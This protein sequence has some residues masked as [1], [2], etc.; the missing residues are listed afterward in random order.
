[1]APEHHIGLS[2]EILLEIWKIHQAQK[3][4]YIAVLQK[5]LSFFSTLIS[6]A[7]LATIVAASRSDEPYDYLLLLVGPVLVFAL[8]QIAKLGTARSYIAFLEATTVIAKLETDMGLRTSGLRVI[9][10][11]NT[12][13]PDE[14]YAPTRHIAS[15][16]SFDAS[17]E[18]VS[19]KERDGYQGIILRTMTLFQVV[20]IIFAIAL[21][22]ASIAHISERL[23]DE[24]SSAKSG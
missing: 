22:G 23:P 4:D 2:K 1:M 15:E 6:A 10:N 16:K 8:A 14:A 5:N 11:P 12:L 9:E 3:M 13:W 21:F 7:F 18:F 24:I 17:A 19:A 20:S